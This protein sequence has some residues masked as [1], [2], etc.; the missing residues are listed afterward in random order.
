MDMAPPS[1]SGALLAAGRALVASA[2]E[3]NR[4]DGFAGDGDLGITMTTVGRVLEEKAA[5]GA[6]PSQLLASCGAEIARRAPS[7]SG[8]LTATAFLR[9]SKVVGDG[10]GGTEALERCFRAALEGV[11][12][13]GKAAV[14][15]RTA[16]DALDAVCTSLAQSVAEGVGAGEA[17][18]RAAKAA[19]DATEASA[20]MVPKA[21][22]ASWV[23]ERAL[24][25]PDAGCKA[26]AIALGAA[27]SSVDN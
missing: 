14:G 3:L 6:E 12:A 13:R 24:G 22:R 18:L 17:L 21:G 7:T 19:E 16:L 1:L 10:P 15:D 20:S 11:K 9:A 23:A 26:L 2:E 27:A 4:L 8:T 25:H 5:T